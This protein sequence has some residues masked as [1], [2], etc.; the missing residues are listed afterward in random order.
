MLVSIGMP[1]AFIPSTIA[2]TSGVRPQ[3][4]GLASAVLNT[5]RMFG[6]ALGLAVLAT[7][8]TNHSAADLRNPTAAI[9]TANAALTNGFQLAFWIAAASAATGVAVAIFGMP[10]VA[11]NETAKSQGV[12]AVEM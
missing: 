9:H 12:V 5:A 6:G 2:A 1:F 8:A 3:E 4:A 7:I 10:S 11:R